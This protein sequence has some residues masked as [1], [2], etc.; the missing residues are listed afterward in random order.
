MTGNANEAVEYVLDLTKFSAD[1]GN[2]KLKI[3]YNAAFVENGELVTGDNVS[4]SVSYELN[5]SDSPAPD[6]SITIG[7][8]ED[9][10]ASVIRGK[11]ISFN[12]TV[13]SGYTKHQVN[14]SYIYYDGSTPKKTVDYLNKT[15]SQYVID[16][17]DAPADANKVTISITASNDGNGATTRIFSVD[18]NE[19]SGDTTPPSVNITFNSAGSIGL[20]AYATDTEGSVNLTAYIT[21]E[22]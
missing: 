21:K 22:N 6:S 3:S 10:P 11:E 16:T 8:L 19:E 1:D 14:V 18:I 20:D 7:G 5:I 17:S 12:P 2:Y 15:G 4:K 9:I 13:S